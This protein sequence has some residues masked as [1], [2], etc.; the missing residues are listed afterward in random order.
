MNTGVADRVAAASSAPPVFMGL[1]VAQRPGDRWA[2]HPD[3]PQTWRVRFHVRIPSQ[4]RAT[5]QTRRTN[6]HAPEASRAAAHAR[7]LA[8]RFE[9]LR[10]VLADPRAAIAALARKLAALGA[11]AHAAARRIALWRPRAPHASIPHG[12]AMVAAHDACRR[13]CRRWPDTS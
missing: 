3:H 9:A 6:T 10:R 12:H 13:W 8:R 7:R 4:S 2:E 11:A 5:A 1:A